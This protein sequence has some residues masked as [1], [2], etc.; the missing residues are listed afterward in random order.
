MSCG[1]FVPTIEKMTAGEFQIDGIVSH[2]IPFSEIGKVFEHMKQ[3]P[4]DLRKMVIL[5]D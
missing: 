1:Q 4:A 3:P 2:Y 5:F